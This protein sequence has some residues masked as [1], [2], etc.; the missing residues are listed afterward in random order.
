MGKTTPRDE[1]PLQ[2]Q[3]TFEPFEKWGMDFIGPID[4]PSRQKNYIIVCTDYLTKW[5]EAKAIKVATEEKVVEF[6]R[7]NVFYKFGYPR[8]LVIDQGNKFTSHM[9]E[10]LLSQHKMKNR[11]SI[12]YHP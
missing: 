8:E 4:P 10:N 12:P 1:M 9:I 5:A 7:E 2:P 6:L 11:T 3:V